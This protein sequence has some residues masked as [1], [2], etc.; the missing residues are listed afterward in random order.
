MAGKALFKQ[1]RHPSRGSIGAANIEANAASKLRAEIAG[2]L[3]RRITDADFFRLL[4]SA[5]LAKA[6]SGVVRS[7]ENGGVIWHSASY[8]A[9]QSEGAGIPLPICETVTPPI[10]YD[11][12][13]RKDIEAQLRAMLK[14]RKDSDLLIALR[15]CD[16]WTFEV[17]QQEQIRLTEKA[18]SDAG[19][20]TDPDGETCIIP[21][22]I[23]F[24]RRDVDP[25]YLPLG[26][27][28]LRESIANAL[29]ETNAQKD[30][31]GPAE[32][33][34]QHALANECI[35]FWKKF[36]E[37]SQRKPWATA[38]T[39]KQSRIVNFADAVFNAAGM[40]LS[41]RRLI[42]LLK[43]AR[44]LRSRQLREDRR[45]ATRLRIKAKTAN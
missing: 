25:T 26:I 32:K 34:Y 1:G 36:G 10:G 4:D 19:Q 17:I 21:A 37:A 43:A 23:Q 12:V 31:A 16:H 45:F 24:G 44:S 3:T 40:A 13:R 15:N 22:E 8:L 18:I 2:M 9:P 33:P 30:H 7:G 11:V 14:I 5:L 42:V 6:H 29:A 39:G 27:T 41:S 38:G 28:G 20:F 35:T